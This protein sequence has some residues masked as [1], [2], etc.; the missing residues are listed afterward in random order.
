MRGEDLRDRIAQRLRMHEKKVSA[1]DERI[2]AREGDL[3]VALDAS[4]PASWRSGHCNFTPAHT[5]S[6]FDAL[7]AWAREG[8]RPAAGEQK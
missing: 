5:G 6:A 3:A 2:R 4:W 8:K 1:L 7:L